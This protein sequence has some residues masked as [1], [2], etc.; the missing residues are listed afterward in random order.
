METNENLRKEI[1]DVIA[2]QMRAN[3]PPETKKT[4]TRLTSM[5]Y[6]A[7]E[8]KQFIGQCLVV[9]IFGAFKFHKPYDEDRY[10]RNLKN[11]PKKPFK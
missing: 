4:Y 9:E 10:I 1:F 8:A 7:F 3:D 5:G 11:L 2:K 6:S